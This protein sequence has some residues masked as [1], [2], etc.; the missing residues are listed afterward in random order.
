MSNPDFRHIRLTMLKDVVHVEVVSNDLQG[1]ELAQQLGAELTTVAGQ[2]WAKRLL[3][4]F[5]KVHHLSSTGFAV[6]VKLV[7]QV[8]GLGHKVKFC[9]M[10]PNVKLGADIIGLAKFVEIHDDE[11]AAL[12]AFGS[13]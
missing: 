1:P 7:N 3:V 6:L 11:N 9:S 8:N 2:E 12:R 10:D 5:S 4:D 13:A